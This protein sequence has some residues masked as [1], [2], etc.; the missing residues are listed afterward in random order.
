MSVAN[1]GLFFGWFL[2]RSNL[3]DEFFHFQASVVVEGVEVNNGIG[4]VFDA[5]EIISLRGADFGIHDGGIIR[6]I[7]SEVE[8]HDA[9]AAM[10]GIKVL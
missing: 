8:P 10:D 3:E 7:H 5:V 2:V 6:G 1:A 4:V 9:V